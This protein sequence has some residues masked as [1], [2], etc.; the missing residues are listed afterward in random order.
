MPGGTVLYTS[1]ACPITTDALLLARFCALRPQWAVCDLGCGGG[2]LL[3]SLVDR[4][5]TGRAVGVDIRPEGPRLLAAAAEAGALANVQAVQADLRVWREAQ[6]FDLVVANPPYFTEGKRADDTARATARHQTEG[7]LGDF[8]AAA[9]RLLKDRGRFCLCY[10]AGQLAA[11]FEALRA[12]R[13]EP[14]RMQLARKAP[15][16]RPWLALVEARKAG[17]A[18]LE[19]LPDRMVPPGN[20]VRY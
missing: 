20:T 16:A 1:G 12:E 4:G 2:V 18:G 3:L 14:K 7:T 15:D 17:G 6:L 13:L 11:L 5:L 8:C 19:I 9:G 10:P